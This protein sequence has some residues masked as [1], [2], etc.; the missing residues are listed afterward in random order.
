MNTIPM[1]E[2][3]ITAGIARTLVS[4]LATDSF[5]E[6]VLQPL[7]S[8]PWP[9]QNLIILFPRAKNGKEKSFDAS[10]HI[11]SHA[12]SRHGMSRKVYMNLS[13]DAR[14]TSGQV[15]G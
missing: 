6:T 13:H 15:C 3:S 9:K 2:Y 14:T 11:M 5:V 4:I 8:E 10:R 12:T 1:S 7:P